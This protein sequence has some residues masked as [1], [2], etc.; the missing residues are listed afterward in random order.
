M[1]IAEKLTQIA[2]NEQKV[3]DAGKQAEY[4]RFWDEYLKPV[5]PKGASSGFGAF[6]FSGRGWNDTTFNP[7][8]PIDFITNGYNMFYYATNISKEKL[9]L[10]DYSKITENYTGFFAYSLIKEV[11][12]LDTRGASTISTL[13][14]ASPFLTSVDNI[15]LKDDGTQTLLNIFNS[16]TALQEVRFTGV[17][18]QN[19]INVQWSTKLTH[20]SLMSII[21]ALQDKSTDTSGTVWTVTLGAENIAKLTAEEKQIA[22]Q[23]GWNLG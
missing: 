18:G 12:E 13:F 23:K 8:C 10:V 20:E 21:N 17:I 2:E 19:G 15:I 3:Y 14:M 7:P 16:A 4:D 11:P 9:A 22:Q 1:S 5:K 6:L